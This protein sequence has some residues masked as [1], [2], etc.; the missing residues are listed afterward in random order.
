MLFGM[1]RDAFLSWG[2]LLVDYHSIFRMEL[3]TIFWPWGIF[4]G[5]RRVE[6]AADPSIEAI[7][8]VLGA[9]VEGGRVTG[10]SSAREKQCLRTAW[11]ER[12]LWTLGESE[13][14]M[15]QSVVATQGGGKMPEEPALRCSQCLA[16]QPSCVLWFGKVNVV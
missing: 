13:R 11:E 5:G 4:V 12:E 10:G 14:A 2:F 16:A 9:S 7:R 8:G 3:R 1:R 15:H 6:V